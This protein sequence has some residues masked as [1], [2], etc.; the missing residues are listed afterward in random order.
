MRTPGIRRAIVPLDVVEDG[1]FGPAETGGRRDG[2]ERQAAK[3][4]GSIATLQ[5]TPKIF[6]NFALV[7]EHGNVRVLWQIDLDVGDD[8]RLEVEFG[9]VHMQ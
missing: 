4:F 3:C 5:G 7:G 6:G 2:L 9:A 8:A 1:G